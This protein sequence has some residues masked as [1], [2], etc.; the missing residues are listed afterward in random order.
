MMSA[1][2]S[3]EASIRY[4]MAAMSDDEDVP[5]GD[6]RAERFIAELYAAYAR[7]LLAFVSRLTGGDRGWAEDVVQET[8]L[9]AWH[10]EEKLRAGGENMFRPWLMTVARRIVIDEQRRRSSRPAETDDAQLERVPTEGDTSEAVVNS[11]T[12]DA[13]MRQLSD[14]HRQ[15]LI[16]TYFRGRSVTEAADV[17]QLPPGTVK[18]RVYYAL[19]TMRQTLGGQ[20]VTS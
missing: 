14:S 8:L 6:E 18:S 16:E 9:R 12:V 1:V 11:I 13:A 4:W 10:N 7:P 17:L 19:R 3:T 2:M 15:V 20:E 5:E